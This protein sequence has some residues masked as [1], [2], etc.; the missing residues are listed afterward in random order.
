MRKFYILL[1]LLSFSSF[2]L[3]SQES[4]VQDSLLNKE[5]LKKQPVGTEFWLTFMQNYKDDKNP[6]NTKNKLLL[7]LFLTS[8]FDANVVIEIEAINYRKEVYVPRETVQNLEIDPLAQIT[9][10]DIVETDLAV[11]ITSDNPISVYGL[12]RRFQTTDTYLG[13]PINVL[14]YEYR[15][16]SY[17]IVIDL[18]PQFAIVATED[19]TTV[20]ITPS[21]E[22]LSGFQKDETYTVTMNK[23]DV[24]QVKS[25]LNQENSRDSD[26]TGS[27]IKADKKISVFSGHQCAY[28]PVAP[29]VIIACNHLVE[30]MPPISSWGKHFYI[31][32]LEK[33][34]TYSY[35]V[36]A[37]E[38]STK[39]F[40]NGIL[41]D[42]LNA[43]D[44]WEDQSAEV[45]QVTANKPV[46][47]AQ[48]SQGYKNGD[49]IGDPMM[50]LISPTQQFLKQY[51]FATPVNGQWD[52]YVNVLVPTDAVNTFKMNGDEINPRSFKK[53]GLSRYSIAYLK[54]PFGTHFIT[55]DE[56]FGM[57][58]YGF[59][60]NDDAFDAYGTMGGQSFLEYVD[61]PDNNL[62]QIVIETD[63]KGK[64]YLV[65]RDDKQND[66]GLR[67]IIIKPDFGLI[68]ER[69]EFFE[70]TPVTRVDF[71]YMTKNEPGRLEITAVDMVGNESTATLCYTIDY[72]S[73]K[74]DFVVS[75]GH[76]TSCMPRTGINIGMFGKYSYVEHVASF[77]NSGNVNTLGEFTNAAGGGG[78]FGLYVGYRYFKNIVLSGRITFEE[79]GGTLRSPDSTSSLFRDPNTAELL[80]VYEAYDLSLNS[81]YMN[82]TLNAEWYFINNLYLKGGFNFFFNLTDDITLNRVIT[83]RNGFVYDNGSTT[84]NTGIDEMG[85][86]SSFRMGLDFGIGFNAQIY[87]KH[88]ILKDI[89]FFSEIDYNYDLINAIND[90][91]WLIDNFALIFGLKYNLDLQR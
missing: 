81:W 68:F 1:I 31:G 77:S 26:L 88:D 40:I 13:L 11:H 50:L 85:S 45:M 38:D 12:N 36:L 84:L 74:F 21:A 18:L 73:N 80:P 49:L 24:Y 56:P 16:M 78:G 28:V 23:G 44:Y 71:D 53:L 89:Y 7:E 2:T 51:R 75:P 9:S 86:L 82:T 25:K 66:S 54:V 65:I 72:A 76:K 59:G 27:Y 8:D 3:F 41:V 90:G 39:V 67:D 43:G 29:P 17:H 10:N 57:Y 6:R 58:S 15:V 52:H 14:G 70:G 32:R 35:R 46:L 83:S 34:T 19:N 69:G 62:P 87:E 42:I 61:L 79:Y 63:Q 60:F 48:Y 64:K 22:T 47:V 33:R 20:E 5:L 37:N 55:C 30:Q 91:D 4:E